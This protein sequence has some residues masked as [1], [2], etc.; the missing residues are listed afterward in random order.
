MRNVKTSNSRRTR[1]RRR[2][3]R[4]ARLMTFRR[5]FQQ[6]FRYAERR[7]RIPSSG[8]RFREFATVNAVSASTVLMVKLTYLRIYAYLITLRCMSEHGV[9][10]VRDR[11]NRWGLVR[12]HPW[13]SAHPATP[14]SASPTPAS[15]PA[16][17][18]PTRHAQPGPKDQQH[19]ADRSRAH[20]RCPSAR[21]RRCH[22][23]SVTG[24]A[25]TATS[26]YAGKHPQ[27]DPMRNLG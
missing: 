17:P 16:P 22:A 5:H 18:A 12:D 3:Q 21:F 19:E 27:S 10:R 20:L 23:N 8:I 9:T 24:T 26:R 7:C 1:P 4:Y 6:T 15:S 13:P 25:P 11:R 14:A 2:A